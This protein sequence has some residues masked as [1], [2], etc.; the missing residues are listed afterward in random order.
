MPTQRI[1]FND[2]NA[3]HEP[4]LPELRDAF[5]RVVATSA[6]SSGPEVVAFEQELAARVGT[7]HAVGVGS[8]TAALHLAL[9]AAGIGPGDE[10]VL[11]PNTFFATAEAVVAA[12]ATPVF[13]D[14]DPDTAL[15]DP[16]AVEAVITDR[17]AALIAVHLYG[18]PA[19]MDRMGEI[20]RRNGLFL[21][22][23][24]AQAIGASWRDRPAGSLGDAA[25]FS[26]YPGKNLGAMGDAG[27][28]VTDDAAHASELL[29][30][31]EHGQREKYRSERIGWT[32]RLDAV[33]A[34]VLSAKLPHLDEWNAQRRAVAALYD[35]ALAGVGDL[36]LPPVAAGGKPVWHLYVVRTAA[37]G[38]VADFLRAR[39]I[40]TGRHY[41]EPPHLSAAYA[42]LGYAPGSFP[43]TETLANEVLSLPVFPGMTE[44]QVD[45]VADALKEYF[46]RG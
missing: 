14:V 17:T 38:E 39:G 26:F 13:A 24:A 23:D 2:L 32:S 12:G 45:A 25:A 35:D 42:A 27:A 37:P 7:S 44:E 4:I 22:E 1:P 19:D 5:E 41:P 33:Q 21:L 20:A 10:V 6:F 16:D 18:Q 9:V 40:E 11:P 36:V 43:V 8:G 34:V 46:D 15:I 3:L 29:L 31:R 28:L 30:L